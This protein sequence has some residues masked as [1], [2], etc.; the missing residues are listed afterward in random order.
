MREGQSDVSGSLVLA[1][2]FE[3]LAK[4][5]DPHY[6]KLCP[7]PRAIVNQNNVFPGE[8]RAFPARAVGYVVVVARIQAGCDLNWNSWQPAES[9]RFRSGPTRT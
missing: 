5:S 9:G 6:K 8:Y 7:F 4:A 2:P 1:R 3:I